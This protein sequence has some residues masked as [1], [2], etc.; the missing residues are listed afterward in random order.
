[1]ADEQKDKAPLTDQETGEAV[2]PTPEYTP[3]ESKR[4]P[5]PESPLEDAV[6]QAFE[7][8]EKPLPKRRL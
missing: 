6:D 7:A 2:Q 5:D 8:S 1:M 4:L 3:G